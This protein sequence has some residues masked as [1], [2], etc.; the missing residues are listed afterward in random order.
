MS[1]S[2][3]DY[4][5]IYLEKAVVMAKKISH[6]PSVLLVGVSG[7]I[8]ECRAKES[9]DIDFFVVSSR[10]RIFTTR[11][12]CKLLLGRHARKNRDPRPAGKICLN[13]FL[14]EDSLDFKPH[15]ERVVGFHRQSIILF[16]RG[17]TLEKLTHQNDWVNPKFKLDRLISKPRHDSGL[18]S[19]TANLLE[20]GLKALQ[21]WKIKKSPETHKYPQ[22]IVF[23]DL[24]LRFHPPK[25]ED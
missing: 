21:I 10:G 17:N 2:N 13:Y 1:T 15:N 14:S 25:V 9:S 11:F 8:S 7:S 22:K 24:E 23:S 12:F 18:W 6:L 20:W 19:V 5:K 3:K 4:N 16:S